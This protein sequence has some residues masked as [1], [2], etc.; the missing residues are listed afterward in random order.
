MNY[1]NYI[2]RAQDLKVPCTLVCGA[3]DLPLEGMKE[4]EKKIPRVQFKIIDNC[5]HLPMVEQPATF[6][7][8]LDEALKG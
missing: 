3:Q 2:D 7:K 5:K 1:Y 8:I 4:L 6:I